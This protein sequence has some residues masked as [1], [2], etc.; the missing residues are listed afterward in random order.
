M[1]QNKNGFTLMEMLIVIAI[2]AVLIAVAIPV[3]ASQLEKTEKRQILQMFAPLM[4]RCPQR[5]CSEIP[6]L[7]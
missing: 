7:P 6:R 2:I 3:F 4:Q 5:R 1:K